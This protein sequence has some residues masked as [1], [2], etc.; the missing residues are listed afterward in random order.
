MKHTIVCLTLALLPLLAG[1]ARAA[2]PDAW[3]L[4]TWQLSEDKRTPGFTDDYM[5]F[6]ADGV[7]TMRDA[8]KPY[9]RCR[10]APSATAVLLTCVAHGRERPLTFKVSGDQRALTNPIGDVYRKAR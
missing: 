2:E 6:L 7:V 1:P 5:D 3:L 9:A 4:G 10:Y 8:K